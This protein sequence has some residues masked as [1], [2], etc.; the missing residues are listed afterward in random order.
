M[1]NVMFFVFVAVFILIVLGVILIAT[2]SMI[3]TVSSLGAVLFII[4]LVGAMILAV[5]IKVISGPRESRA[6]LSRRR[7]FRDLTTRLGFESFS[8]DRDDEFTRKWDFLHRLTHVGEDHYAFNLLRGTYHGQ[9]LF[10]FDFIYMTGGSKNPQEH[11]GTMFLLIFKETFP[12]LTI[13]PEKFGAKL[14]SGIGLGGEIKFESA[15]FSKRFSVRCA[16]KKF[17]YDICNPQ[18]IDC[19][20]ANPRLEIEVQGPCLLLAFEPQLPVE[21]IEFNLQRLVQIR[22]LMPDYLFTQNA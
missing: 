17:A 1:R 8:P 21:Q 16:D 5:I 7:G 15:E 6:E 9:S 18:M 20:L 2:F 22:S 19:L 4:L 14:A 10:I 3:A 11:V 13:G 12:L